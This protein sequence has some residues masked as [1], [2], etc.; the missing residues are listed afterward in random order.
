MIAP[1]QRLPVVWQERWSVIEHAPAV[2]QQVPTGQ[3]PAAQVEPKPCQIPRPHCPMADEPGAVMV[4]A[5]R[6]PNE[7]GGAAVIAVDDPRVALGRLGADPGQARECL[8][9]AGDR[10]D[11]DRGHARSPTSPAA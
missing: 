11:E 4:Q 9:Q 2:V 5:N 6:L 8:D 3:V 10:F 1:F 7:C